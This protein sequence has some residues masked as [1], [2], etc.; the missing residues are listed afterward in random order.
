MLIKA[1]FVQYLG[2]DSIDHVYLFT[3]SDED[4][5]L[6]AID[7]VRDWDK[8]T[9]PN[10]ISPNFCGAH[11]EDFVDLQKRGVVVRLPY[12]PDAFKNITD[13]FPGQIPNMEMGTVCWLLLKG[14]FQTRDTYEHKIGKQK[15]VHPD[16]ECA[17]I[18]PHINDFDAFEE[19]LDKLDGLQAPFLHKTE[20]ESFENL[21]KTRLEASP[22]FENNNRLAP[23]HLDWWYRMLGLC[24]AFPMTTS[25]LNH[26]KKLALQQNR[27]DELRKAYRDF[28]LTNTQNGTTDYQKGTPLFDICRELSNPSEFGTVGCLLPVALISNP[29]AFVGPCSNPGISSAS[30]SAATAKLFPF[31]IMDLLAKTLYKPE[32]HY[33]D[34]IAAIAY[35]AIRHLEIRNQQAFAKSNWNE[36]FNFDRDGIVPSGSTLF[37]RQVIQSAIVQRARELEQLRSAATQKTQKAWINDQYFPNP[38]PALAGY[39]GVSPDPI[40]LGDSLINEALERISERAIY[41]DEGT[42]EKQKAYHWRALK[43]RMRDVEDVV[44]LMLSQNKMNSGFENILPVSPP[45]KVKVTPDDLVLNSSQAA[46]SR[47]VIRWFMSCVTG[48]PGSGKSFFLRELDRFSK[49]LTSNGRPTALLILGPTNTSASE[50]CEKLPKEEMYIFGAGEKGGPEDEEE[51]RLLTFRIGLGTLD[52]FLGTLKT[53]AALRQSMRDRDVIL[54]LDETSMIT[55]GSFRQAIDAFRDSTS[56]NISPNLKRIILLGDPIQLKPQEPD[57]FHVD[58]LR[59][60]PV[61]QLE[62]SERLGAEDQTRTGITIQHLFREARKGMTSKEA[63]FEFAKALLD[64]SHQTP[65]PDDNIRCH[66]VT[67][68][69]LQNPGE[70]ENEQFWKRFVNKTERHIRDLVFKEVLDWNNVTLS[71][72]ALSPRIPLRATGDE[73]RKA[74]LDYKAFSKAFTQPNLPFQII[75]LIRRMRSDS[76]Q[77]E[78]ISSS[79]R[80]NGWIHDALLGR[81]PQDEMGYKGFAPNTGV[82]IRKIPDNDTIIH[83]VT[84]PKAV[85]FDKVIEG[86]RKNRN[87]H[88]EFLSQNRPNNLAL[89]PGWLYVVKENALKKQY[90]ILKGNQL[91]YIGATVKRHRNYYRFETVEK[92]SNNPPREVV[93][94][95]RYCTNQY[96]GYGWAINVHQSQGAEYPLVIV[97]WMDGICYP[98]ITANWEKLVVPSE[99]E[100]LNPVQELRFGGLALGTDLASLDDR[101][102]NRALYTAS[103]RTK[104][105][106]KT[107]VDALQTATEAVKNKKIGRVVFIAGRHALKRYL[108]LTIHERKTPLA[109][110]MWK[111]LKAQE[112]SADGKA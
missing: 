51:N 7:D 98:F 104:I 26:G 95:Q 78:Y 112:G 74:I 23:G 30:S 5:G 84:G 27:T 105:I 103:T 72:N 57:N 56:N 10:R 62:G 15:L 77:T 38:Y 83:P 86:L 76:G 82:P 18:Y 96:L 59:F 89:V 52:S 63:R 1:E 70:A 44:D 25:F 53:S 93:L 41:V 92:N 34:R 80:V 16:F 66:L 55:I 46:A 100:V 12:R 43:H 31:W 73:R 33:I 91:R 64:M 107:E 111:K 24:I 29:Y 108:S 6:M 85:P 71:D 61:T 32:P 97:I 60:L 21:V 90:G 36:A 110:L 65:H 81:L 58:A 40:K 9:K 50:A 79:E 17:G 102:D 48:G 14:P 49:E 2:D 13:P 106:E 11:Y 42:E 47:M 20:I 101:L 87:A 75:T 54:A 45:R 109:G 8:K 88:Q 99:R 69:P 28:A 39:L 68:I 19:Q 4:M 67:D 3:I 37:S 22:R 35:E 94:S